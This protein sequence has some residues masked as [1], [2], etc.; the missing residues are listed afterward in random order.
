MCV[1]GQILDSRDPSQLSGVQSGTNVTGTF[2]LNDK[3]DL[4]GKIDLSNGSDGVPVWSLNTKLSTPTGE[5]VPVGEGIWTVL[6]NGYIK[7]TGKLIDAKKLGL[8]NGTYPGKIKA[9]FTLIGGKSLVYGGKLFFKV[10]ENQVVGL[11]IP[12]PNASKLSDD[13]STDADILFHKIFT[14]ALIADD[15]ARKATS[16]LFN[17]FDADKKIWSKEKQDE[18]IRNVGDIAGF[19][20]SLLFVV[21]KTLGIA[22]ELDGSSYKPAK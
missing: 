15:K 4:Q 6:D 8:K 7:F 9:T 21:P 5:T 22:A 13:F 3:P 2:T 17:F 10:I 20:E 1:A 12:E 19:I 18:V 14:G 11:T 16:D